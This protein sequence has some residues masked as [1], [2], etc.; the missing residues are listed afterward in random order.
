MWNEASGGGG[1]I[2]LCGITVPIGL[3]WFFVAILRNR[4]AA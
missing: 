4:F 2:W 3:L 1:Y